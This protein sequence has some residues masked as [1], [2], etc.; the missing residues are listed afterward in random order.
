MKPVAIISS[1]N[2]SGSLPASSRRASGGEGHVMAS[3][4]F[5]MVSWYRLTIETR[6]PRPARRA[7]SRAFSVVSAQITV[8]VIITLSLTN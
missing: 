2:A 3:S 4:V 8:L 6:Y 5:G 1:M 7:I